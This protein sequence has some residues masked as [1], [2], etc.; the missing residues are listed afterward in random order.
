MPDNEVYLGDSVYVNRSSETGLIVL[1]THNGVE[2]TNVIWL[3]P[4]VVEALLKWLKGE[5]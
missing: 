3:E 5:I 1:Y 4:S 2:R